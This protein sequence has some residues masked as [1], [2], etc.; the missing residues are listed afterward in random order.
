MKC[1]NHLTRKETAYL[2]SLF[3]FG[4]LASL[5]AGNENSEPFNISGTVVT[6]HILNKM[7]ELKNSNTSKSTM[8]TP[9]MLRR[10][11]RIQLKEEVCSEIV[12]VMFSSQ[13]Y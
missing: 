5:K 1:L 10:G 4:R 11:R 13:L 7:K 8:N 9:T 2:G 3:A 6:T 12:S